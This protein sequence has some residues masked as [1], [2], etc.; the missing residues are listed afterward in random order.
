MDWVKEKILSVHLD[1][2]IY[3]WDIKLNE[4]R[5]LDI[6]GFN[7]SYLNDGRI[8]VEGQKCFIYDGSKVK[9]IINDQ[10]YIWQ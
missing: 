7:A 4:H 9:T 6:Q 1:N 5:K 8:L 2:S 3:E 10:A